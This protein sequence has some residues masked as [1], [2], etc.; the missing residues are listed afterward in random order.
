MEARTSRQQR[1]FSRR[2]R[3]RGAAGRP[4]ACA[5]GRP[6]RCDNSERR[7]LPQRSSSQRSACRATYR[8]GNDDVGAVAEDDAKVGPRAKALERFANDNARDSGNWQELAARRCAGRAEEEAQRRQDGE[9]LG[10][11]RCTR[12]E[13]PRQADECELST[14]DRL[15]PSSPSARDNRLRVARSTNHQRPDGLLPTRRPDERFLRTEPA[16]RAARKE[17]PEHRPVAASSGLGR[18]GERFVLGRV[19]AAAAAAR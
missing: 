17:E 9:R 13:Q 18:E 16:G 10:R 4:R 1:T 7:Q 14:L 3:S 19:H 8:K 5:R 11:L 6:C 15:A 12:P 2:W